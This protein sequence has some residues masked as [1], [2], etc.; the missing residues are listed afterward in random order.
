MKRKFITL[1]IAVIIVLSSCAE[2][3]KILESAT[4]APLTEGDVAG[5]LKE[6]LIAGAENSARRL[7]AEN[8]YYGDN[9]VKILLPEEANV[10]IDNISKIPGGQG[11]VEDVVLRINRAAEDAA[12]EVAPIFVN[13]ITQMTIADAWG[14]LRGTDD[15]ATQYLRRTTYGELTNLYRPRIQ[16]SVQK[17][18]VG[19]ISTQDSWDALTGQWNKL[20]NSVAGRIA[21]FKPVET[22][23]GAYLTDRALQGMFMKVADEEYKIRK[24]INARVTPLMKR[25]FGT[26]DNQ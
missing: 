17:D 11:L 16:A 7:A 2:L 20:A 15:A 24:D 19:N 10:I 18:I 1:S 5:G 21:G 26:L 23:L 9:L 12:K 14:I 25:V 8:G 6:A 22:D 4:V 13:S 3:T